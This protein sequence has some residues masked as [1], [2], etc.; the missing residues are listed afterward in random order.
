MALRFVPR[1]TTPGSELQLDAI[2]EKLGV[3]GES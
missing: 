2:T 1:L 3:V